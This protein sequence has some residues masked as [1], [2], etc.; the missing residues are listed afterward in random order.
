M[1]THASQCLE[2]DY[3]CRRFDLS[4]PALVFGGLFF[5]TTVLCSMDT[6]AAAPAQT[7]DVQVIV[8]QFSDVA[9]EPLEPIALECMSSSDES[10]C[11]DDSNSV[12]KSAL[13]QPSAIH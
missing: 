2:A 4:T 6:T 9:G 13:T 7:D 8:D 5:A 10:R 12:S 11:E 1:Y 3:Q